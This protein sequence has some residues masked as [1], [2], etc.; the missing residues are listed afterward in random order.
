MLMCV[1][2]EVSIIIF[3]VFEFGSVALK[4]Y[5]PDG[6]ID[7]GMFFHHGYDPQWL[8]VLVDGSSNAWH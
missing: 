2:I 5:L 8:S 7:V 6:D 3:Q 4:T 1:E